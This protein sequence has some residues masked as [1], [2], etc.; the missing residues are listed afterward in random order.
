MTLVVTSFVIWGLMAFGLALLIRK[1]QK[2][3]T[4]LRQNVQLKTPEPE[5]THLGRCV[6]HIGRPYGNT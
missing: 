1:N 6:T 5:V 4:E 2:L 3:Y